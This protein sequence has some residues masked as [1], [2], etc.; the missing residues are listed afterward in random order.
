VGCKKHVW[1]LPHSHKRQPIDLE[2][3]KIDVPQSGAQPS[4]PRPLSAHAGG[5]VLSTQPTNHPPTLLPVRAHTHIPSHTHNGGR[6][7]VSGSDCMNRAE[8]F[9]SQERYYSALAS[10][11][12]TNDPQ[13]ERAQHSPRLGTMGG[14]NNSLGASIFP[15]SWLV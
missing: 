11:E 7:N 4:A 1:A 5:C 8:L 9:L 2:L 15:D 3:N 6:K 14:A 12:K 10:H 13:P